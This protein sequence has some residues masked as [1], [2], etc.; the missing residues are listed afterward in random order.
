VPLGISELKKQPGPLIL[1]WLGDL[2]KARSRAMRFTVKAWF[3]PMEAIDDLVDVDVPVEAMHMMAIGSHW[4]Y[5]TFSGFHDAKVATVRLDLPSMDLAKANR[6]QAPTTTLL[7][8]FSYS[9]AGMESPSYVRLVPTL[10]GPELIFP[11]TEIARIWYLFH[12]DMLPVIL[13][14]GINHPRGMSRG[15]LPWNPDETRRTGDGAHV[16][17]R[18][19]FGDPNMKRLARLLFDPFARFRAGQLSRMFREL[20]KSDRF[21]FPFAAF[22]LDGHPSVKIRYVDVPAWEGRRP[23]RRLVLSVLGIDHPPPYKFLTWEPINDNRRDDDGSPDR[24]IITP[25]SDPLILPDDDGVLLDGD[26]RDPRLESVSTYMLSFDDNAYD[27]PTDLAPR[28]PSSHRSDGGR[29]GKPVDV[30]TTG[31]DT[32]GSPEDGV[33][34]LAGGDML[35]PP[36]TPIVERGPPIAFLRMRTVFDRVIEIVAEQLPHWSIDYL[37]L[38]GTDNGVLEITHEERDDYRFLILH[39]RAAGRHIYT[40]HGAP[41]ADDHGKSHQIFACRQPSFQALT[42]REFAHWLGGFPYKG[43]PVWVE[44]EAGGLKLI[45]EARNHQP[46]TTPFDEHAWVESFAFNIASAVTTLAVP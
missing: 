8:D 6:A 24:P 42:E 46:R 14:D 26:G 4:S 32:G 7:P 19:R 31:P 28:K 40:L 44:K 36:K 33:A 34:E 3:R 35:D 11:V 39:A 13:G 5:G 27:V 29:P 21:A 45:P 9:L 30:T 1:H 17:Y 12:P 41:I 38:G 20:D 43:R 18:S 23:A 25:W 15:D 37:A 22:P 10:K 2:Q 16:V